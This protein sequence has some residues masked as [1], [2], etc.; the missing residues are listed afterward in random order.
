MTNRQLLLGCVAD[1]FTGATD[2]A[3]FL[4][5]AGLETILCTG[6]PDVLPRAQAVV[7]ALKSRTAPVEQAVEQT[8][9]AVRRLKQAGAAQ[10]YLKYCSTFDSTRTGNIGPVCDALLKELDVSY[11]ILCP[12]LPVNGRTV[13]DGRLFVHGVPLH[14]SSMKDHP[15]TPMWDDRLAVLMAQQSPLPIRTVTAEDLAKGREHVESITGGNRCYLVPDFYEDGHAKQIA[16]IFGHLPLLT[17][18]S[19]LLESLAF[20]LREGQEER[21]PSSHPA[22]VG[23]ALILAG[24]CSTAT[25]G[26][27]ARFRERGA[28]SLSIHPEAVLAGKQTLTHLTDFLTAHPEEDV[29]LYSSAP[30]EEVRNVQQQWGT[31]RVS[32][33]LENLMAQVSRWA[34]DHG[35]SRIIVAGG[36]TSGAVTASLGLQAFHIGPSVAPSVPM[37]IPCQRTNLR[38]VLKSGNFGGPDFFTQALEQTKI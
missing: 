23:R 34:V 9:I 19:G 10:I 13:R 31:E 22:P 2:A 27:I 20:R 35:V 25:L 32:A 11:T 33:A 30:A 15:L 17:G 5:G 16:R 29:L 18:G 12:A 37:I 14:Q 21:E 1:D 7:I 4:A 36:E 24:S 6:V 28:C 38:L 3:S 26:Q 8:L